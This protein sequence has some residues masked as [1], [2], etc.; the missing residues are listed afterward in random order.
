MEVLG[1]VGKGIN[2]SLDLMLKSQIL[3]RNGKS[4]FEFRA[5]VV[6]PSVK[7]RSLLRWDAH[8]PPTSFYTQV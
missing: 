3:G 1:K 8:K 2:S 7:G 5:S 6:F 4:I